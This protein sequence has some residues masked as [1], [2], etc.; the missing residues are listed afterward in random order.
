MLRNLIKRILGPI[1]QSFARW[2][3][4]KPRQ[5]NFKSIKGVVL[6]GV[7]YPHF[8]IS[9]KL[10]LE[11]LETKNLKDKSLLE[12]GCG[13]GLISVF[14][15]HRGAIVTAS[16]INTAAV[17][18]ANLNAKNNGVNLLAVES[19]LFNNLKNQVFDFI[20]INPPYYPKNPMN[21]AE[22]A[23]YCG[24]NFEYFQRLFM[25][26]NQHLKSDTE[27]FMILSEDCELERIKNIAQQ[28]GFRFALAL[29]TKKWAEENY[30]FSIEE[31]Q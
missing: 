12:L 17:N 29:K 15:A 7:F 14:A 21:T 30:I 9:T 27:V 10:L 31:D 23:W 26:L 25:D 5:Y 4:K 11:F 22:Q 19:D 20:V 3:F 8:T 2:Y 1:M 6:P 16:D 28:H 18:N 24:A 13:T